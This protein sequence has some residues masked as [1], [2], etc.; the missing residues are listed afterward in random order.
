M[1]LTVVERE[2]RAWSLETREIVSASS[3]AE[4][5]LLGLRKFYGVVK[6]RDKAWEYATLQVVGTIP[7][8]CTPCH[9]DKENRFS[10]IATL[11]HV[12]RETGYHHAGQTRHERKLN[13]NQK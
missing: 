7:N 1:F 9:K 5:T 3:S 13:T 12:V 11:R 4:E 10:T 2:I 6:E 8:A